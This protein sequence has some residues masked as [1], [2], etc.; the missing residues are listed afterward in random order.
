M[1][2]TQMPPETRKPH[3]HIRIDALPASEQEPFWKWVCHQTRPVI[4][5][6]LDA[7]G[8]TAECA[9]AWDYTRW[10]ADGKLGWLNDPLDT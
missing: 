2:K 8:K 7:D 9:Y 6:E 4:H 1:P 5:T 3:D 10:L